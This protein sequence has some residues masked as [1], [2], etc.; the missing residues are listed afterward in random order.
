MVF[1]DL[2]N[3]WQR[4]EAV[5]DVDQHLAE[6]RYGGLSFTLSPVYKS[7]PPL[8]ILFSALFPSSTASST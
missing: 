2:E 5:L 4:P 7:Q 3:Q 1:T 8:Y 6:T